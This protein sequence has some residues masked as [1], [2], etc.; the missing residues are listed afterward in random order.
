MFP[1]PY[2][3]LH[4]SMDTAKMIDSETHCFRPLT[5]NYISQF[6]LLRLI[7]DKILFPSPYGEL[8]FSMQRFIS[9]KKSI[10]F[11]PLTGNYISQCEF[12][13]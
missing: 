11:R 9:R 6:L 1:S 7:I 12:N 13:D 4:F 5:G 8:H 2:G 3:E 10:S